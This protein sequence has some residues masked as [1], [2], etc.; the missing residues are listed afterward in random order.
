MQNTMVVGKWKWSTAEAR[1]DDYSTGV[2]IMQNTMV[3]GK[4]LLGK[5]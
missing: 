2:Y 3:V 1:S 5:K 4:W